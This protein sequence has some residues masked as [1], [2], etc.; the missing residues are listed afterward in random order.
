MKMARTILGASNKAAEGKRLAVLEEGR[1]IK[2]SG[3]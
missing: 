2:T 1:L 3:K